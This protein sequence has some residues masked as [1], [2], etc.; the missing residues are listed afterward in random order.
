MNPV[1]DLPEIENGINKIWIHD[2]LLSFKKLDKELQQFIASTIKD[3]MSTKK[4]H[5]LKLILKRCNTIGP[6]VID[7]M[8]AGNLD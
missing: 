5:I 6:Q 8:E 7:I 1:T 3:A 2:L 4:D